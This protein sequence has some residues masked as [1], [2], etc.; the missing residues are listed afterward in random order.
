MKKIMILLMSV[1]FTTLYG[2]D[3][4]IT[5]YDNEK[6]I[7]KESKP[8][9][10]T[11][12]SFD[13]ELLKQKLSLT[14]YR[15]SGLPGIEIEFPV[16]NNAK[17]EVFSVYKTK[18][19]GEKLQLKHPD[20]NTYVGKSLESGRSIYFTVTPYEINFNILD[21]SGATFFIKQYSKSTWIGFYLGAQHYDD[22]GLECNVMDDNLQ[23]RTVESTLANDGILRRYRYAVSVTGEYSDYTLNRLG[24]PATASVSDKKTAILGAMLTTVTRMNSVYERDVAVS[25]QL[26]SNDQV[27][28][29]DASSDPFDNDTTSMSSLLTASQ[30]SADNHI[31]SANYD[32]G[33]VWCQGNLQGLARRPAVC[34]NGIKA[35]GAARGQNVE[36]DR[37]IISVAS[38]ELGHM[39]GANHTFSNSSCGGSRND[40]TAIEAGSGTTIMSYAGICSPNIQ[41]YTDDRFN[42]A[43]M[44]E[45]NNTVT[46]TATCNQ[47]INLTNQVPTIITGSNSYIP[48]LTPFVLDAVVSDPD[49]DTLS[50][51]WE[52]VDTPNSNVTTSP[53]SNWTRGPMF[54]PYPLSQNTKRYFPIIDTLINNHTSHRW[55]VLPSVARYLKFKATVRDNNINGGQTASS[56][57]SLR[58]DPNAGPFEVTSDITNNVWMLGETRTITWNVANTNSS[59]VNCSNVDILL[60]TDGGYTYDTPL[61]INTPNDGSEDI[62]VPNITATNARYM[63]KA[64]DNYFFSLNQGIVTIGNFENHCDNFTNTTPLVITDNDETTGVESIIHVNDNFQLNGITISVNISHTYIQDIK[65]KLVSPSGTEVTLI[66]HSCG[67][68][69]NII[70]T[71]SDSGQN[72]D[73]NSLANGNIFIPLQPLSNFINENANGDWKLK[74]WDNHVGDEGTIN[75]WSLELCY[76]RPLSIN[77]NKKINSLIIA[78]NPF[79]NSISVSFVPKSLRQT[80]QI[81][82]IN[83]RL[84]HKSKYSETEMFNK[85]IDLSVLSTGVYFVKIYDGVYKSIAKIIKK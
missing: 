57:V 75:S 13:T 35:K 30:T 58:V 17:I 22:S 50:I 32:V 37:F 40:A 31:G 83:G 72:L 20:I 42:I 15:F 14:K 48:K 84:I 85:S 73:C 26:V 78:P 70:A 45:I 79:T 18:F 6:I 77:N 28:Y 41:D 12:Y 27:I 65:L 36:S 52:E 69:D 47:S 10:F 80:I 76:L 16:N 54:R 1:M 19:M 82:D 55:E 66:D 68:Q 7:F 3:W 29:L 60:S 64:H 53:Q 59:P 39:F 23:H 21:P 71:F 25:L 34:S 24:I 11:L 38:H 9:S 74:A 62:T 43:S 5:K 44:I 2:Q 46:S 33:Q 51:A 56:R 81:F 49:G 8:D 63:V 67:S 61:L 4:K